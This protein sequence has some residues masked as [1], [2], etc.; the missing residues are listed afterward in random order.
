MLADLDEWW[1]DEPGGAPTEIINQIDRL[2][3]RDLPGVL[4]EVDLPTAAR[5]AA[6]LNA[7][8]IALMRSS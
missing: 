2:I 3:I 6:T 4:S 7:S 1:D 8:V 5:L